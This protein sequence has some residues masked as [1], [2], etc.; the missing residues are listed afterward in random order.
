[1][2][3]RTQPSSISSSGETHMGVFEDISTSAL[4]S[5][6]VGE[7]AGKISTGSGNVYIGY[8]TGKQALSG[9]YTTAIG[10]QAMYS[11]A[12]AAYC[13]AV[14]AYA[15]AQNTGG[16]ETVYVGFKCG[17]KAKNG[18]QVTAVGA[19][20]MNENAAANAST[21]IGYRAAERT[22][23]GGYC[24]F[25]GAL[26]GQDNRNSTY[27]TMAGYQSGRASRGD[28]NS[29]FG[30]FSGYSNLQGNN[31]C[32]FGYKAGEVT[33][34]DFNSAFGAYAMQYASG[35]CNVAI[36]AFANSSGANSSEAVFIGANVATNANATQSVIVGT[37]A[38]NTAHGAGL[39]ILGYNTGTNFV[40]GNSN[41]L[42]GV[43]ANTYQNSNT[44]CIAIGSINTETYNDAISIG[45]YI[46]NS[47]SLSVLVGCRLTCDANQSVVLGSTINIQSLQVFKDPLS[48]AYIDFVKTDALQKL[49]VSSID[50]T[51]SLVNPLTNQIYTTA[52]ASILSSNIINSINNPYRKNIFLTA[53]S[54]YTL[55][56]IPYSSSN[57]YVLAHGEVYPIRSI[58]QYTC[59]VVVNSTPTMANVQASTVDGISSTTLENMLYTDSSSIKYSFADPYSNL[60]VN[61][62]QFQRSN[63]EY[64]IYF[65]KRIAAPVAILPNGD[66]SRS[67]TVLYSPLAS[68]V[69][70]HYIVNTQTSTFSIISS[71]PE[72]GIDLNT[73]TS[74][75]FAI[76]THPVYGYSA[77]NDDSNYIYTPYIESAY[78]SND[79][80]KIKPVI[81][82]AS[83]FKSSAD[84]TLYGVPGSNA[85]EITLLYKPQHEV[86]SANRIVAT[87]NIVSNSYTPVYINT[88]YV[89]G[90]PY[91]KS[92]DKVSFINL[93]S[94]TSIL[95]SNT[96][97]TISNYT[98]SNIGKLTATYA[99]LSNNRVSLLIQSNVGIRQLSNVNI[100]LSNLSFTSNISIPLYTSLN[101]GFNTIPS[102]VGIKSGELQYQNGL[103]SFTDF[104]CNLETKSIVLSPIALTL[105]FVSTTQ[106]V[107]VYEEVIPKYG[108]LNRLDNAAWNT[109]YTYSSPYPVYQSINPWERNDTVEFIVIGDNGTSTTTVS[110]HTKYRFKYDSSTRVT[111]TPLYCRSLA[112]D[113]QV[114]SDYRIKYDISNVKIIRSTPYVSNVEI[115]SSYYING[116]AQ[117]ITNASNY[118]GIGSYNSN[119]GYIVRNSNIYKTYSTTSNL[120]VSGNMNGTYSITSNLYTSLTVTSNIN[121]IEQL[122]VIQTIRNYTNGPFIYPWYSNLPSSPS[123]SN[124]D[125]F[126]V[127]YQ[128]NIVSE[129][130]YFLYSCNVNY[131]SQIVTSNS[132]YNAFNRTQLLYTSN[133]ATTVNLTTT[134]LYSPTSSEL[135]YTTSNI[136][137]TSNVSIYKPV[138]LLTRHHVFNNNSNYVLSNVT[139]NLST[140][141][142]GSGRVTKW[143]MYDVTCNSIYIESPTDITPGNQKV[144]NLKVLKPDD[145][146]IEN[147]LLNVVSIN[148]SKAYLSNQVLTYPLNINPDT[149][150][151]ELSSV[152]DTASSKVST[153]TPYNLHIYNV[154]RGAVVVATLDVNNASKLNLSTTILSF[155]IENANANTSAQYL[156]TSRYSSDVIQFYFSDQN[157]T[158]ASQLFEVN[159]YVNQYPYTR[160][161]YFNRGLTTNGASIL[162]PIMFH[163]SSSNVPLSNISIRNITTPTG[164]SFS[165]I[166]TGVTN[167]DQSPLPL[168]QFSIQDVYDGN[169]AVTVTSSLDT[170]ALTTKSIRYKVFN[171]DTNLQ[172]AQ[173][174]GQ[175]FNQYIVGSYFNNSFPLQSDID[176][177]TNVPV[178]VIRMMSISDINYESYKNQ[179][180]GDFWNAVA[181]LKI[182]GTLVDPSKLDISILSLNNGF[183]YLYN[184]SATSSS[185][186]Q[187]RINYDTLRN[188][189]IIRYIPFNPDIARLY[190]DTVTFQI[191]Y[192]NT[193]IT[194]PYTMDVQL[195]VSR[196]A[197]SSFVNTLSSVTIQYPITSPA[198]NSTSWTTTCNIVDVLD[199]G[200]PYILWDW[201]TSADQHGLIS[202]YNQTLIPYTYSD[203]VQL[204]SQSNVT[205]YL[206]QAD[207]IS[208][209]DVLSHVSCNVN[210][211]NNIHDVYMYVVTPPVNG[212]IQYVSTGKSVARCTQSELRAGDV[213]YQH[214][215]DASTI[216]SAAV[217]FSTTP[218]DLTEN[219]LTIDFRILPLPIVQAN[220]DTFIYY[221]TSNQLKTSSH[222][223]TSCN[224]GPYTYYGQ[225]SNV[226]SAVSYIHIQNVSNV[227]FDSAVTKIFTNGCNICS[228]QIDPEILSSHNVQ[229]V[230]TFSQYPAFGFDFAINNTI[231][232]INTLSQYEQY[233]SL[234]IHHHT[235]YLNRYVDSNVY[236]DTGS[237][238]SISYVFD[239]NIYSILRRPNHP[240]SIT[241]DVWPYHSLAGVDN[242]SQNFLDSEFRIEMALSDSN[243]YIIDF[244]LTTFTVTYTTTSVLLGTHVTSNVHYTIDPS[245]T[246][247]TSTWNTISIVNLDRENYYGLSIYL[248]SKNLLEN[249]QE[250]PSFDSTLLANIKLVVDPLSHNNYL[251]S[252]NVVK[253][254]DISSDIL[255]DIPL[256]VSYELLNTYT[257]HKFRDF[258][259]NITTYAVQTTDIQEVTTDSTVNNIILGNYIT[260]NGTNN[261]CI[262]NNFTTS[263]SRSII[264]GNDNGTTTS[265]TN[266]IYESII[267]GNT[268]FKNSTVRN[269]I[270][271]GRDN[272][273]DLVFSDTNSVQKFLGQKPVIIGNDIKRSMIDYYVNIQDAFLKTKNNTANNNNGPEQIYLGHANEV[274]GIGY[275]NNTNL[276]SDYRLNV[277]GPVTATHV[278]ANTT[279]LGSAS[280]I[281]I[282]YVV[283]N[284]LS[285]TGEVTNNLP[286]V[287]LAGGTPVPDTRIVG[288]NLGFT[289][290]GTHLIIGITGLI[291]VWCDGE[292][293]VGQYLKASS[294]IAG[295]ATP[296]GSATVTVNKTNVVFAK[297]MTTWNGGI[298][299]TITTQIMGANG[300]LCGYIL[301]LMCL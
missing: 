147:T 240:V 243:Y 33:S 296:T 49:G 219:E 155:A 135:Q 105:P 191:I 35:S 25:I 60:T 183:F 203:A 107:N 184:Q 182:Q 297:S 103:N 298:S 248:N 277:N 172:I 89:V 168:P 216:D 84:P 1:M 267:I 106:T 71:G 290:G 235:G 59:N 95:Y 292:V 44:N 29:Y 210:K 175:P 48:A 215:G 176:G 7:S 283:G 120:L 214:Y 77:R 12:N 8:E 98:Y 129:K 112:S 2:L 181:N 187:T 92:T 109:S 93:N 81:N 293:T 123:M 257:I 46:T 124:K 37:S 97:G 36:G 236:L 231:D 11:S 149:Q 247:T 142:L 242:K 259:V 265:G 274:V 145:S 5:V 4:Q 70:N 194:M 143:T 162:S 261:I 96:N 23:D 78:V 76:D 130:H 233:N 17:E 197:T 53:S 241:V 237:N 83:S 115:L 256:Y 276:P 266:D 295:T 282:G 118:Y 195:Y 139:N 52:Q 151:V 102:Y 285:A 31:S 80:F 42:I 238:I 144:F 38:G 301:C 125:I 279:V 91:L 209:H 75:N 133:Y 255:N 72:N 232:H 114:P 180:L 9:T 245:S 200:T 193:F 10:Y 269:V 127:S 86:Y 280:L 234:F 189:D 196:F 18:N 136:I 291:R 43:G 153:F 148:S 101:T 250:I 273:N 253:V 300:T 90:I 244:T 198:L 24:V 73:N 190:N 260:V 26:C 54:Q 141:L 263:G 85:T 286:V 63:A 68:L 284:L 294:T 28:A 108:I 223:I 40:Y 185:N 166:R 246:L 205:L 278:T 55:Y 177:T 207:R 192:D 157:F 111:S 212:I 159:L 82:V 268:S 281:G 288:V 113:N 87:S 117:P 56:N 204:D 146:F 32:L 100:Q 121:G 16:N 251:Q 221:N 170:I 94:N 239:S 254:I 225:W 30:A 57:G 199:A 262:G 88:Q 58:Y 154:S 27:S 230:G 201:N 126:D 206:D 217:A 51:T 287:A 140:L 156:A 272:L 69:N 137:V 64:D 271:I 220:I 174:T 270:N 104:T 165:N 186:I 21:A 178:S 299:D 13:T 228:L 50:Y 34:G 264:L 160:G 224:I 169:I 218:Y 3:A 6:R 188:E 179:L 161:Q 226:D 252:S 167:A 258:S 150:R 14:G 171:S 47:K 227:L 138:S 134:T 132:Y 249:Q 99:D 211:L 65:P 275:T 128:S 202:Q 66:Q 15:A 173:V 208:L 45:N 229:N 163:Y 19:Y 41:I 213:V 164:F 119:T 122:N 131:I 79:S 110:A 74:S 222:L 116:V 22:L 39:V 158:Q 289:T 62:I 67:N 20:A 61:I 152:I